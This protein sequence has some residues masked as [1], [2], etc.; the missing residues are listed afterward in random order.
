MI[1]EPWMLFQHLHPLLLANAGSFSSQSSSS[2][3][4][5]G[6]AFYFGNLFVQLIL[7]RAHKQE[8]D[9]SRLLI[10]YI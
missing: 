1:E 10:S 8:V 5:S 3:K 6:P 4:E 9:I 7:L 2:L